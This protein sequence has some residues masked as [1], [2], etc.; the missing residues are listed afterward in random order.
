M[1]KTS[2]WGCLALLGKPD[3]KWY[4]YAVK[5]LTEIWWR[6]MLWL[7]FMKIEYH[8]VV[9]I[10]VVLSLHFMNWYHFPILMWMF[11]TF[12]NMPLAYIWHIVSYYFTLCYVMLYHIISRGG[13][14]WFRLT[15]PFFQNAILHLSVWYL[16]SKSLQNLHLSVQALGQAGQYGQWIL[17]PLISYHIIILY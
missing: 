8:E 2:S 7:N 5:N 11:D 3:I 13:E 15:C 9:N 1:N 16:Y 6:Q 10:T 17:P 14:I 12:V 4:Q